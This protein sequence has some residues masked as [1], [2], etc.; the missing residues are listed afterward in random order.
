MADAGRRGISN[1]RVDYEAPIQ[2][3]S[4]GATAYIVLPTTYRFVQGGRRMAGR[5]SMTFVMRRDGETWKIAS[6]TYAGATPAP[7]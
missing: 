6:W 1:G 5:G 4:D 7:E 2:A 3:N